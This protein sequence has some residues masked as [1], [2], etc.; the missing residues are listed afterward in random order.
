MMAWLHPVNHA[1]IRQIVE[2][3]LQLLEN[4]KYKLDFKQEVVRLVDVV[5]KQS[6]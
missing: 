5:L 1:R 4:K 3:C 2:T 6:D